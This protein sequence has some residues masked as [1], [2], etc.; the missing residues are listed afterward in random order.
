[1]G[2]YEEQSAATRKGC[3]QDE[4]LQFPEAPHMG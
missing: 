3:Q 1:V 2:E 4:S